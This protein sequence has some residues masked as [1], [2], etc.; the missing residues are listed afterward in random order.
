VTER[1]GAACS[2]GAARRTRSAG[3]P[4]AGAAGKITFKHGPIKNLDMPAMTMVFEVKAPA[5]LAKVKTGA[6]SAQGRR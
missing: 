6:R 5:V 3:V 2:A 4:K 1:R